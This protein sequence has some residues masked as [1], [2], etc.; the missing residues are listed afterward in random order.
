MA[1]SKARSET[2]RR[3]K[4]VYPKRYR[5]QKY[6]KTLISDVAHMNFD[7]KCFEEFTDPSGIVSKYIP[8]YCPVD[9]S[10]ICQTRYGNIVFCVD[11]ERHRYVELSPM[12]EAIEDCLIFE[13]G[14]QLEA[15]IEKE[16][17]LKFKDE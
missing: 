13:T 14:E 8:R 11:A 2:R 1:Y 3:L 6:C 15:W 10:E 9:A 7:E 5:K 12:G 16:I 17:E 4:S